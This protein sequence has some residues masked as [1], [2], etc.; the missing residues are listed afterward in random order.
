MRKTHGEVNVD[1]SVAYVQQQAWIQNCSIKD[2]ILLCKQMKSNFYENVIDACELKP[3]LKTFPDR[4][5]TEI[6]E[7][8]INLSGGQKQRVSLAR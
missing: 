2:N 7:K 6:G 4:D 1:G 5:S 3:D 8:G